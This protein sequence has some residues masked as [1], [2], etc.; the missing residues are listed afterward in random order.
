MHD[1]RSYAY[2]PDRSFLAGSGVLGKCTRLLC[3]PVLRNRSVKE[4]KVTCIMASDAESWSFKRISQDDSEGDGKQFIVMSRVHAD[5]SDFEASTLDVIV[6]SGQR[7]WTGKGLLCF[8]L[9]HRSIAI[10]LWVTQQAPVCELFCKLASAGLK[11]PKTIHAHALQ[12]I[13]TAL[14]QEGC[15]ETAFKVVLTEQPDSLQ[16]ALLT[17]AAPLSAWIL[18]RLAISNALPMQIVCQW[19]EEGHTMFFKHPP[20][21]LA[22]DKENSSETQVFDALLS[23]CEALQVG[24]RANNDHGAIPMMPCITAH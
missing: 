11:K 23:K 4:R 14:S 9:G 18:G 8:R 19:K 20:L 15:T 17:L 5:P 1:F 2:S 16:V 10:C 7:S 22:R 6:S 3:Q 13:C 21:V 12:R 24:H